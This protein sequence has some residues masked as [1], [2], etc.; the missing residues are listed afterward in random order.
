LEY[1]ALK[2]GVK[3]YLN[4]EVKEIKYNQNRYII[5]NQNSYTHLILA[6]GSKAMGKLGASDSGYLLAKS[7]K[8]N[9]T[10]ILPSLV[11]LKSSNKNL[12]IINGVK[13]EGEIKLNNKK[14]KYGDILFTKYGL[15]G[16]AILDISRQISFILQNKK[17]VF[18]NID[19]MPDINRAKLNEIL[20]KDIKKNPNKNLILWL[21]SLINKKLAKYIILNSN[22][23]NNIKYI[24]FLSYNHIDKIIE[25]IK[26]LRFTIVDT[27]GFDNC[28][29]CAGGIDT[30][31]INPKTMESKIKKGLYFIGE[32]LDIDGDCGGYNLHW[33]WGS[34][35]LA[36]QAIKEQK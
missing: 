12:D 35:L 13:I 11:Q 10:S 25:N 3:I 6:T 26:N 29:V 16:S 17:E 22:I 32:V 18:L 28:E 24:K 21:N 19:I 1:E 8:H 7:L 34:A 9:I 30:K 23:P 14:L 36:T 27:Q 33:A 15:S 20:S 4:Y 5:N 31:D 2:Y